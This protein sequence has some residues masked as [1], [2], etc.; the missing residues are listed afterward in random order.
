[1]ALAKDQ[2]R[3]HLRTSALQEIVM[4]RFAFI[5]PLALVVGLAA[6]PALAQSPQI[7]VTVGGDLTEEV[8]TLG[9]REVDAQIARLTEM[10]ARALAREGALQGAEINLVLT[11][12]KPNRPTIEQANARPGLSVIDSISIG[13]ATIEGEVVTADG[14]RLP[15]RYSRYST[16]LD[17]V[18]GY[19]TWNDAERAYDRLASNLASGRLVSH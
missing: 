1:M 17:E 13:G 16:S 4:R 19:G 15:V 18:I 14:Q 9:Q 2:R 10:V 3:V 8:R 7:N 11:D 5:A 12:L 6:S